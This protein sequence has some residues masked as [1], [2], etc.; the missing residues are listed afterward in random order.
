MGLTLLPNRQHLRNRTPQGADFGRIGHGQAEEQNF[1]LLRGD[2][3][4]ELDKALAQALQF[5]NGRLVQPDPL[6]MQQV[7]KEKGCRRDRLKGKLLLG[8]LQPNALEGAAAGK[9]NRLLGH[10]GRLLTLL[11][12]PGVGKTTL[13]LAVAA[14]VQLHYADGV[15]FVPLAAVNEPLLMASTILAAVGSGDAGPKPPQTKLIEF[16]RR[17]A[18]LLVL[19]NLEQIDGAAPL[20]AALVAECAGLCIL[21]TSR[22]RLHL[23]AEQRYKV[24]PLALAAAVELFTQHAQAIDSDFRRTPDNQPILEAICQRLDCLPLALELCAAQIDLLAPTHLLAQLQ[25]HRLDLLVDG[26]LDLPP[27]QRTLR[28]AIQSSERLLGDEERTLLHHLGIFVGGCV[29]PA[30]TAVAAD[31]LATFTKPLSSILHALIDKNLL[32]AETTASGER[33]FLL[34]EMIR[35]FAIEQLRGHDE[36]R[37]TAERHA[38]YFLAIAERSAQEMQNSDKKAGLDQL[39][40]EIDNLRAAFRH[41]LVCDAPRARHAWRWRCVSFGIC[42]I[43]TAKGAPGWRRH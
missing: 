13:A 1:A 32:R 43:I 10:S 42:V 38:R 18:M 9:K 39:E 6:T 15:V 35:E 26:A 29:L 11:G 33:R 40:G 24:P 37:P 23:R 14:R 34:L 41:L 4:K 27:Q 28:L 8:G 2:N 5:G 7:G 30:V 31:H 19:D 3:G 25:D 16:L 22:E 36:E 21:V 12:P 20:L 17:K